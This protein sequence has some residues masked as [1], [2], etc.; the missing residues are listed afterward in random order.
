MCAVLRS[1]ELQFL[2]TAS[3]NK[4]AVLRSVDPVPT[5]CSLNCITVTIQGTEGRKHVPRGSHAT[6]RPHSRQ[7]WLSV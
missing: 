2:N 7:P 6:G 4:I 1:D 3:A 5:L